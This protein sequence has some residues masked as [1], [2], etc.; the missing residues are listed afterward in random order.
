M[1]FEF[2]VNQM[3]LL[4]L[5]ILMNLLV[6]AN[7]VIPVVLLIPAILLIWAILVN[8]SILVNLIN[9]VNLVIVM[10]LVILANLVILVSLVISK[11][12]N[13]L[14]SPYAKL[15]PD[16]SH[17]SAFINLDKLDQRQ[18]VRKSRFHQQ[19]CTK[20]HRGGPKTEFE[21]PL[22][23]QNYF[24]PPTM[25]AVVPEFEDRVGDSCESGNIC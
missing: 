25:V 4:Y 5:M 16:W 3:V 2:L 22:V 6:L 23:L 18:K 14:Q 10:H 19:F 20:N 1:I 11:T 21:G 9:L 13:Q 8:P 7:L 24:G 12:L 15:W 17:K